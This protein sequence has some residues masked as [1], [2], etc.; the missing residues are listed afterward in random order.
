MVTEEDREGKGEVRYVSR[1]GVQYI[2]R[3]Y[4]VEVDGRMDPPDCQV[5]VQ[6]PS[7]VQ[8]PLH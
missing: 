4:V 3:K 8:E 5:Q 6:T 1:K 2:A 7:K